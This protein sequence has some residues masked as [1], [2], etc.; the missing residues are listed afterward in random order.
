MGRGEGEGED[1][2]PVVLG[3]QSPG[4][5]WDDLLRECVAAQ[6]LWASDPAGGGATPG[7]DNPVGGP[8]GQCCC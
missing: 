2:R 8:A 1:W 6:G 4:I 5:T 7:E 3:S